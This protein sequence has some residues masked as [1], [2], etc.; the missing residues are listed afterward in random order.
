MYWASRGSF[1]W[2]VLNLGAES[3]SFTVC[4]WLG[5]LLTARTRG[6]AGSA[7]YSSLLSFS[8]SLECWLYSEAALDD[9]LEK[10]KEPF[11]SSAAFSIFRSRWLIGACSW[12]TC[13]GGSSL[14]CKAGWA[15]YLGEVMTSWTSFFSW[16]ISLPWLALGWLTLGTLG[17]LTWDAWRF[18]KS[19]NGWPP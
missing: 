14:I 1:W 19:L 9:E 12:T 5:F 11:C 13:L 8:D 15:S 6:D 3:P 10:C 4:D 18:I 2:D 16:R 7:R 17:T